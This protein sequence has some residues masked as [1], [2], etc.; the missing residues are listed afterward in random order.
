MWEFL[1][2]LAFSAGV[3]GASAANAVPF[4]WASK[5][6]ALTAAYALTALV[7][8]R[9]KLTNP[10]IAGLF[11]G[12]DCLALS[13]VLA[14][15]GVLPTFG[16]AVVGP[17]VYAVTKRGSNPL[18]LGPIA[19]ASVIA[20]E[21]LVSNSGMPSPAVIGQAGVVLAVSLLSNHRRVVIRPQ[22]IQQ[23]I[24]ELAVSEKAEEREETSTQALIE[25]REKYRRL[26]SSFKELERRSRISRLASK[27]LLARKR[28]G[29]N[30]A[31][32]ADQLR[33]LLEVQA[34]II[35]TINQ[36]GDRMIVQASSGRLSENVD[37]LS[38]PIDGR[39]AAHQLRLRA[40][41]ALNRL[42][43]GAAPNTHNILLK[44]RGT[45]I[46]VV[47]IVGS[48]RAQIEEVEP[49]AEELS[50]LLA[51]IVNDERE[52]ASLLR[53]VQE[54]EL[55]YQTVCSLDGVAN[56]ADLGRRAAKELAE[57]LQAD[58][59]GIYL[60]D[61]SS[62]V[63]VGRSGKPAPLLDGYKQ[64]G[65]E[66][67]IED[68]A[69]AVLAYAASDSH[70]IDPRAALRYRIG[71]YIAV[72]ISAGD[73]ILGYVSAGR[74]AEGSLQSDDAKTIQDVAA[75]LAHAFI[76]IRDRAEALQDA[77]PHGILSVQEFQREVT[78][79]EAENACLVYL[80]PISVEEQAEDAGAAAIEQTIRQI[81]FLARR[82]APKG[83]RLCRKQNGGIVVLLPDHDISRA[84]KWAN[85]MAA[86]TMDRKY[87]SPDGRI[88]IPL[89]SKARVADL[90]ARPEI[91]KTA[92]SESE[93]D[94][95]RRVAG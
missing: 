32:I 67:W 73:Q 64:S 18:A 76:A 9:R 44:I 69:P 55:L 49:R 20:A 93:S 14:I 79:L 27:L 28:Y 53:R 89:A 19:A 75:E 4:G 21:G 62:Q 92:D 35:Y 41:D 60:L 72:P 48:S 22:T 58:H 94:D 8:E 23:M 50:E 33:E 43:G 81:G 2:R 47:T 11:A 6:A 54:A 38:F 25:L 82:H 3:L 88:V 13:A 74:S 42:H 31:A 95:S 70:M 26:N 17:V 85:E 61:G 30:L 86:I 46:G 91:S 59:V 45:L 87:Q 57:I 66:T 1:V 78:S 56:E 16:L 83:A 68:G 39:E 34:V 84:E 37:E 80:E 12:L 10:G 51:F 15:A 5:I 36:V 65:I 63:A 71:S 77:R 24:A 90:H 7:I 52:R 29:R 40:A